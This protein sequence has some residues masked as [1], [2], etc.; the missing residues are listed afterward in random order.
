MLLQGGIFMEK[1]KNLK[2]IELLKK[3]RQLSITNVDKINRALINDFQL[4]DLVENF[5]ESKQYELLEKK[6]NI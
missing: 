4:K 1:N 6:D 5:N 3:R 2:F